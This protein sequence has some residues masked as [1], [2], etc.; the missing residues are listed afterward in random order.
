M[1]FCLAYPT[2][3]QLRRGGLNG[4]RRAA[5]ARALEADRSGPAWRITDRTFRR[6]LVVSAARAGARYA[7]SRHQHP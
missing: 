7:A 4:S 5:I 1:A 2:L 3:A 6:R